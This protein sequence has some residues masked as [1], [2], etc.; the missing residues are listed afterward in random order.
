MVRAPLKSSVLFHT[1]R[2]GGIQNRTLKTDLEMK[3]NIE[4]DSDGL[5][6]VHTKKEKTQPE[7]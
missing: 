6:N 3:L 5:M 1:K 7:T 4:V 2:E